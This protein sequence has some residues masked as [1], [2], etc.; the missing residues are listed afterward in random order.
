M[1]RK[2]FFTA[3]AILTFALVLPGCPPGDSDDPDPFIVIDK[4]EVDALAVPP[5]ITVTVSNIARGDNAFSDF[6]DF[7]IDE[8]TV[9]DGSTTDRFSVTETVPIGSTTSFV[10]DISALGSTPDAVVR[11]SGANLVDENA[12]ASAGF[13]I[14]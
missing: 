11:V 7:V 13:A 14:P 1:K 12:S 8:V 3:I 10:I 5:E 6:N 4:V 2:S 9:T